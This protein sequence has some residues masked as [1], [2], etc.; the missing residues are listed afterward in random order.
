MHRFRRNLLAPAA[1]VKRS[2]S[3]A[4]ESLPRKMWGDTVAGAN[5]VISLV[6]RSLADKAGLGLLGAGVLGFAL[7]TRRPAAVADRVLEAFECG[8]K[9]GWDSEFKD[10]S[11][12]RVKRPDLEAQLKELFFGEGRA[13]YIL[14]TKGRARHRQIHGSATRRARAKGRQW[15][16][17][18]ECAVRP[19]Q[20]WGCRL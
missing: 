20:V 12:A 8:G 16:R 2:M 7:W 1:A 10:D 4:T 5:N 13:A 18:R 15:R 9:P 19:G 3:T 17:V 14:I 6:K 11:A